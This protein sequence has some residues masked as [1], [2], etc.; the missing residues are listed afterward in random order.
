[1]RNARAR[2]TACTTVLALVGLAL[3]ESP[4]VAAGP[5]VKGT[6]AD[7][8]TTR[9]APAS[10]GRVA[11]EA[12]AALARRD[13]TTPAQRSALALKLQVK[14]ER[15]AGR[16]GTVRAAAGVRAAAVPRGAQTVKAAASDSLQVRRNNRNTRATAVANTL[17]EP[18]AANDGNQVF[19][20]GNTF[21]ST[22]GNAGST[23]AASALP[24]GPAD[25]SIACCDLDV[26][27]AHSRDRTFS[28]L[29]YTNAGQTN[30]VVRI[31]VR[32]NLQAGALCSYLID[33]G[34]AN[35]NVLPDYPH[36][37]VSNSFLY[38]STNSITNG[39][40][41]GA[42]VRR[43]NLTQMSACQTAATNT[44]TWT[45]AVGQRILTPV[46]GATTVMYLG[47]NESSTSFRIFS[48]PENSTSLTTGTRAVGASTFANPDC[49]GGTGNFD[50]IE[51]ATAWSIAGFRM[52]GAT[53]GG[54]V[55][56]WWPAAADANHPQA[57]LH[58]ASLAT[59]NLALTA[60][61]SVWNATTCFGFPA[62]ASNSSGDYGMSLAV[63]GKAGGG[64]TAAQGTV[65]VD[66][67]SSAGIFF[68]TF[69]VT[70]TGTHNR[71]DSRY[72]DYFT[73]RTNARCTS[74]WV[75]TNYALL[76][77]N[78]SSANVNARYVEMQSS[79]R[80]AC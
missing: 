70:A 76:N 69:S 35:N 49:R 73:V 72:G 24:A 11:P 29:L 10:A 5:A 77:G 17:A 68:P 4:S 75:A 7:T 23:W 56:F 45:G 41:T 13:T 20:S 42:Q 33:P 62:V 8:S 50:F 40:W 39:S 2:L 80:P 43:F 16:L 61:P 32:S 59:S 74:N 15:L 34:G 3:V 55:T 54:R 71:S 18:S 47:S 27:R 1:M 79:L 30:G 22:S 78:T 64:G 9:L 31:S 14:R 53:G 67:A 21:S 57:H 65:L 63:G 25:A 48:W 28:S 19:Y 36:L 60:Q 58:G 12:A 38:L 51:R 26:V 52:R 44:F 46:E 66:D 37:A 6:R